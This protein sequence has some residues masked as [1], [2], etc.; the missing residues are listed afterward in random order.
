[1]YMYHVISIFNPIG[2][3]L[4]AFK[5]MLMSFKF[6]YSIFK[7]HF[8]NLIKIV[9]ITIRVQKLWWFPRSTSF[10]CF[11]EYNLIHYIIGTSVIFYLPIIIFLGI[12]WLP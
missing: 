2:F 3:V 7:N 12:G 6:L 5:R 9:L 10:L 8:L 1:M 11:I 4:F